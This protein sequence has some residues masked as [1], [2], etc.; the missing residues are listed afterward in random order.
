[1]PAPCNADFYISQHDVE[2]VREHEAKLHDHHY[3][4]SS[5]NKVDH[6]QSIY[7]AIPPGT[8][9]SHQPVQYAYRRKLEV[10]YSD[11]TLV[12][13]TS[14]DKFDRLSNMLGR[15]DGPI[16]CAVYLRD[17]K[18]ILQ[19]NLLMQQ[20]DEKFYNLVTI[21]VLLEKEPVN[22]DYPIN[23]MRNLA[24]FNIETEMFLLIDVDFATSSTAYDYLNNFSSTTSQNV[25]IHCMFYQH[26]KYLS[27]GTRP[28]KPQ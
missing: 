27:K 24:L 4:L 22:P 21:H 18:E 12:T 19:L 11:I 23:L 13:Q 5:T 9:S 3:V 10:S 14:L 1:M 20:Q 6:I 15:W 25:T 2:I 7:S 26:L 16:S 28:I 17:M 8:A